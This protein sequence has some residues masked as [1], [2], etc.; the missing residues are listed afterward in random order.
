MRAVIAVSGMRDVAAAVAN[1]RMRDAWK[2]ADQVL[3]APKTPAGQ[4]RRF[5]VRN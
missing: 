2:F 1:A 3:H 4:N 5:R